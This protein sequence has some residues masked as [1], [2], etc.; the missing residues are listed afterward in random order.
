ARYGKEGVAS[1]K[2]KVLGIPIRMKFAEK[3]DTRKVAEKLGLDLNIPTILIMGGGQG[4]GPMKEAVKGLLRLERP[5]QMIV[6][7][8]TN[9]KLVHW[10]KKMQRH[11]NKKIIYYDYASNVDELMGV[12]TL[13]IS[14]PGGMTTSEC[15]AKG[16]P[17]VIVAPIPG[18]E[19]RNAQ[20]LI[21]QG[22]AVRVDNKHHIGLEIE[23]LLKAPNQLASMKEA[24]MKHGKP[25]AAENIARLILEGPL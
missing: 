5:L 15:L 18:Q 1:D 14:K 11:T 2:I 7:C 4:L 25:M 16:L 23:K 6:I 3:T 20:F 9:V 21:Q 17:M 13:I 10:I 24:A 19:E 8:G 12:S 22:I